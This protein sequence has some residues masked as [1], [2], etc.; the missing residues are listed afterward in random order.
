MH[1]PYF[2][3]GQIY[4]V[5]N[6]GVEK[7]TIFQNNGD[8]FRFI[9]DLFEFND[10]QPV[11]PINSRFALAKPSTLKPAQLAQSLE[12][13]PLKIKP[14]PRRKR[15]LLVEILAFCL[16]PNHFHLLL[17]QKA[18]NGIPLFMQKLG[19]G[20]TMSFN[21]KYER[22][23]PLFQGSFKAVAVDKDVYFSHLPFYIHA[24]PVELV[25][26]NW[27]KE[28]IKDMGKVKDFLE[29]IGRAHV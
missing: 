6:R 9:H 20:Y 2:A 3:I 12:V 8:Y 14:L 10:E 7:R 1:K 23:G 28:G 24:N 26:P 16:M 21:K 25:A 18:E 29:E 13:E 11:I 15:K 4:H 27:H 22:V 17:R 5:Y 19:T